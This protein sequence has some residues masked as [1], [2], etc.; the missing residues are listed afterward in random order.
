MTGGA[1]ALMAI[2]FTL[3]FGVLRILNMAHPEV[4]M[5]GAYFGL[6]VTQFVGP[7]F[8]VAL[9]GAM[10]GAMVVGV[11]VERVALRYLRGGLYLSPVITTIGVSIFLQNLAVKIWSPQQVSYPRIMPTTFYTVGNVQISSVQIVTFGTA[12]ILMVVLKLVIDRTKAGRAI[13]ATAENAEVASFLGVNTEM[14]IVGTIAIASLLGGAA[15]VMIGMLY[16]SASPF[17]G[18]TYGLKA[19]TIMIVGGVGSIEGAIVAG[20]L[21]GV[22]ESLTVG[23]VSSSWRDA[24]AFGLLILVLLLRPHGIFGRLALQK[25]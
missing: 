15:G 19:L 4:F 13:R 16:N 18:V 10:L 23:Y 22:I 1:Y 8:V 11:L 24:V 5:M 21:L 7:N 9:V 20:L 12:L 14:V 17:M 2:G 25:V 3:I 6:T